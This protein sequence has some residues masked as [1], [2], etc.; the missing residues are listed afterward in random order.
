VPRKR[1]EAAVREVTSLPLH[2][3][4][5]AH[6]GHHAPPKPAL[7]DSAEA[8]AWLERNTV[9]SLPKGGLAARLQWSAE[10][11]TPLRVKLGIDPTAPDI[12]LGFTV[13]LGKLREFQELGHTVVLIIG[14]WTA[15]VG[16]PSGRSE[17]RPQLSRE[18]IEANAA[19]FEQ[20]A[21]KV[22]RRD[23]LEVRH[24]SEWLDMPLE[25][26]F[27]LLRSTTVAQVTERDDISNRLAAGSPV[28]MLELL[29]P[30]MQGYDSVA[31]ESDVELGGTD[32]H[33]NLL[34]GRDLQR[35]FG[36]R[37]QIAMELP[38][39]VG[40]DGKRKMSKSLGN[41]IGVTESAKEIYGKTLSIPDEAI[42]EWQRMLMGTQPVEGE[43]PRD[44]KRS[45]ARALTD[46]FAGEG[47]GSAA[48]AAFDRQFI[49]GEL[50]EDVPDHGV[51]SDASGMVHLP[52]LVADA[53]GISRSEARRGLASG[54]V[55][56]DA[57]VISALDIDAASLDGLILQFGKR[58]ACRLSVS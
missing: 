24:N 54:A 18:Q 45:L 15:M 21:L 47:S 56:V 50:P 3:M 13:V 57:N 29:Y 28:S 7:T 44:A 10:T 11:E 16:D 12:H 41:Y 14:D 38:I 31:I 58:R 6:P 19:T 5:D 23:R 33:F 48:E 9:E 32:Q 8:A 49:A 46:R 35:H 1:W 36:K 30:I 34:L 52:A 42:A 53:F 39:L 25:E 40:T 51:E 26:L 17:T 55:K 2:L 27:G 37:E 43:S 22:L 20:Q 4:S